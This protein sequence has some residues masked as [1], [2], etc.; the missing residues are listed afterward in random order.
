[1]ANDFCSGICDKMPMC[2]VANI[3]TAATLED[4]LAGRALKKATVLTCPVN[5]HDI[6]GTVL[7]KKSSC[8]SCNLCEISCQRKCEDI[9]AELEK[10]VFGNLNC[11]NI[12][13]GCVL[14]ESTGVSSETKVKG[15]F[16]EKRIDIV[17]NTSE[18]VYL[19]KVLS[20]IDKAA[21]Y[22]RSYTAVCEYYKEQYATKD[23]VPIILVP[24]A[25]TA[26]AHKHGYEVYTLSGII[27]L[28]G[29]N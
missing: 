10:V 14:A 13:L 23:F 24:E 8:I 5:A 21:F 25:K 27:G 19:I 29:G 4:I 22:L 9:N 18:N 3:V 11:L 20:N 1:M 2:A 28:A 12:L 26:A 6:S 15:N 16:R 7:M 17:L